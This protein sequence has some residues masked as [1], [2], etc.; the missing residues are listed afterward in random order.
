MNKNIWKYILLAVLAL[1]ISSRAQSLKDLLNKDNIEKVVNA[2]TNNKTVQMTG[3]WTFTGS[4]LEFESDNLLQQAGGTL[5]ASAVEKKLDEQLNKIGIKPGE[6]SFTF[7]TDSTFVAT[8]GSKPLNGTYS[9]DTSTQKVNLKLAKIVGLNA[10][11]NCTSN[12]MDLLFNADKLLQLLTS[13]SSKSNNNTLKSIG[14][15]AE[16]YDGML[17]GLGLEKAGD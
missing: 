16:S 17:V 15:L 14:S 8:I 12:Q 9:Y 6:L 2:V 7:N 13:L 3:T 11:M 5:A 4:A 10:K 1:P